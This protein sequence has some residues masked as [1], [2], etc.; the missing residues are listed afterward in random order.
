MFL[1]VSKLDK[2]R[3]KNK[4]RL[5]SLRYALSSM[6]RQPL[7]DVGIVLF[8]ALSVTLPATIFT[9]IDTSTYLMLDERFTQNAYQL[10]V[11]AQ[12]SDYYTDLQDLSQ[13][14]QDYE[15][16]KAIDFVPSTVGLLLNANLPVWSFYHPDVPMPAY[17]IVDSRVL[18]VTND[19]VDRIKGE[20]V[21]IGNATLA[22]GEILVSERVVYHCSRAF[23]I[24]IAPGMSIG[25]GILANKLTDRYGNTLVSTP[26]NTNHV[27]VTNLT[28]GGIY[29]LR[30]LLTV[31]A[32]AF[33]SI[34]RPDP[35]PKDMYDK[36]SVLGLEDSVM[37]LPS[38]VGNGTIAQM[39]AEGF[40]EP[41]DLIKGDADALMVIGPHNIENQ[42]HQISSQIQELYPRLNVRGI[43][44]LGEIT[45]A[46]E[47]NERGQMLT[48]IALPIMFTALYLTVY[49]TD[50]TLSSRKNEIQILRSKG[51]SYNQIT[52]SI[53]WES[54]I[55]AGLAFIAG[56]L[57][58]FV[59][60]PVLGST[61][62]LFLININEYLN[63]MNHLRVPSLLLLL[64]GVICL[65]LPGL[66]LFHIERRIDVY[67]IGATLN[68]EVEKE[69][70]EPKTLRMF[71]ALFVLLAVVGLVPLYIAPQGTTGIFLFAALAVLLVVASFLG[72]R[73]SQIGMSFLYGRTNRIIGEKTLYVAMSLRKRRGRFV[74]LMII[75]TLSLSSSV[76]MLMQNSS[77]TTTID[78]DVLYAYGADLR[79]NMYTPYSLDTSKVLESS[80]NL[81]AVTPVNSMTVSFLKHTMFLKGID[82]QKYPEIAYF[83]SETF[84]DS[85]PDEVL[86]ALDSTFYGAVIPDYYAKLY[87]KSVGDQITVLENGVIP[88]HLTIVGTMRSAPGFGYASPYQSDRNTV[89]S[90]LGFQV[91]Q[92][93]FMLVNLNM[94]A[95]KTNNYEADLFLGRADMSTNFPML[96]DSLTRD[97]SVDLQ[98]PHWSL[99][100][101][102]E[103]IIQ[104]EDSYYYS[105][106]SPAYQNIQRFSSG[107]QGITV[108]G[109]GV[110]FIMSM[111]AISL[112]FGSAILERKSEYAIFRAVGATQHQV[113]SVVFSEFAGLV[114]AALLASFVLGLILG[115]SITFTFF[116]ISPF[117]PLVS[118]II[119]LP[120]AGSAALFSAE[121]IAL[122]LSCYYPARTAGETE[123]L[124]ELRNL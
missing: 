93:G 51:A 15:G 95:L 56:V 66:Y 113:Y 61:H 78:N 98:T 7:R 34:L 54:C 88:I 64:S 105:L 109:I 47:T 122:I 20:F 59:L 11:S 50:S 116:G 119:S 74:P 23:G 83:S 77:V 36:E 68:A 40:F 1:R 10:R 8:L 82:A 104:G 30:S 118:Q 87:E 44:F 86:A 108:V 17:G 120:L 13:M 26:S 45:A 62:E 18:P 48:L 41:V 42:F 89:A 32:E 107:I 73:V 28:I 12:S 121:F 96:Y 53:M 2:G 46:V 39:V 35:W 112:F 71:G 16:V 91:Q 70:A 92:G 111:S 75:L 124:R 24:D 100:P 80:Y 99:L 90:S 114:L 101:N 106:E 22:P 3:I 79:F 76:M 72:S 123:I 60:A 43:K 49:T 115:Y 29:K 31:A 94:I 85:T 37:I 19:M 69:T 57:L 58:T 38:E 4:N 27:A 21:W 81:S 25:I 14:N 110:C 102:R 84:V 5:W 67:E 52:S 33:P 97:F 103:V 6:K 55:L 9:W 63:F 117:A 65:F